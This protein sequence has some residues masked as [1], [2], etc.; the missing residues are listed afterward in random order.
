MR[1]RGVD[2]ST[3]NRC[4]VCTAAP[5]NCS[6]VLNSMRLHQLGTRVPQRKGAAG[7]EIHSRVCGPALPGLA[8]G[9]SVV[10]SH[11]LSSGPQKTLMLRERRLPRKPTQ[12]PAP[13]PPLFLAGAEVGAG[14]G[15]RTSLFIFVLTV[16]G[17]PS[18]R[19]GGWEEKG[20]R[21]LWQ[22]VRWGPCLSWG[23][24]EGGVARS[25][26]SPYISCPAGPATV[27]DLTQETQVPGPTAPRRRLVGRERGA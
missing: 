16:C 1:A 12:H 7:R 3:R 22:M 5:P 17:R 14:V 24:G 6:E 23:G 9:L 13:R 25:P 27:M 26:A 2:K 21:S 19:R 15:C 10:L 11:S 4:W 8:A 20:G 18:G